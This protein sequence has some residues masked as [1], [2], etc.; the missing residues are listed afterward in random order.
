MIRLDGKVAVVTGSGQGIGFA[1]ARALAQAGA[2]VVVNDVSEERAAAAVEAI[3]AA[4]GRALAEVVPV[5]GSEAADRCVERAVSGFGRLDIMCANAGILRDKVLWNMTDEDFDAV[6]ET[7]L[8]GTFTC[9]RAA[10]RQFRR[11]GQGGRLILLSSLAGQRGNFGQTNY[12]AAK[13]GIAAFAR[14][15]ALECARLD[16]TVNAVLPVA[17]TRM[18]ASIPGMEPYVDA[19][20]R[21]EAL[22]AAVRMGIGIWAWARR[23]TS[24]RCSFFLRPKRRGG[25]PGNASAWA[26]T[27]FRYGRTRRKSAAPIAR[28]DGRRKRSPQ[29]GNRRSDGNWKPMASR[30][31]RPPDTR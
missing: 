28:A 23:K 18:M 2:A 21:G 6:I 7:H 26:A 29:P 31:W 11:Q 25:S 14:T 27:G 4:G 19:V 24:R 15:W 12:A 10:V 5:G 30:R 17:L 9:A 1:T 16:V 22:P 20:E 13:A 8:R 3:A